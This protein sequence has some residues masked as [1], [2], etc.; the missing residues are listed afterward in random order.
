MT[1]LRGSEIASKQ[2]GRGSAL[3]ETEGL[4]NGP[5]VQTWLWQ[6][7]SCTRE[8]KPADLCQKYKKDIGSICF[9]ILSVNL[10]VGSEHGA[11]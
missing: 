7:D 6:N 1:C 9:P 11:G 3:E 5:A 10:V 8:R 4:L 2:E